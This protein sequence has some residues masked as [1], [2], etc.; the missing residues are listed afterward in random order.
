MRKT[1][2]IYSGGKSYTFTPGKGGSLVSRPYARTESL[3]GEEKAMRAKV[4][5]SAL[6]SVAAKKKRKKS[7]PPNVISSIRG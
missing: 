4:I 7:T 2:N 3:L 6:D 5:G 1:K